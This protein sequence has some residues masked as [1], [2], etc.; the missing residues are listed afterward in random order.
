[1]D[2]IYD[3]PLSI[4]DDEDCMV[5]HYK[6]NG[7]FTVHSAYHVAQGLN[8]AN[9]EWVTGSSSSSSIVGDKFWKKLWNACVPGK[10]KIYV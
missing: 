8:V 1:M 4:K 6:R 5:W 7:K 3:I 9:G 2:L 10:V